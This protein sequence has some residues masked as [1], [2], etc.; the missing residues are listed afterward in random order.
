M[1]INEKLMNIQSKLNAPKNQHN[2]FGNY[3]YRSCEDI[4][5]AVKPLL[6]ENNLILTMSDSIECVGNRYYVR[7]TAAIF[8]CESQESIK[9]NALAREEE[10]KKGMDASQITGSTSSYARKYAL[11][12]LFA[13]DDAKDA[14]TNE[15]NHQ[16]VH[17]VTKGQIQ[18]IKRELDRTGINEAVILTEFA[19]ST[20]NEM[21]QEQYKDCM[22]RFAMT[23]NR[24]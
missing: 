23:P 1:N 11:N 8:D 16:T 7:A 13:I 14:D 5:E 2:S 22:R 20:F 3:N 18:S 17:L 12:G 15:Q 4:V 21:T 10:A 24:Q 19:V 6:L 9:V